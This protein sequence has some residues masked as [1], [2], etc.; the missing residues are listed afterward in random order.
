M[1]MRMLG[2][3][4]DGHTTSTDSS[5]HHTIIPIVGGSLCWFCPHGGSSGGIELPGL[6][7]P[8]VF[9]PPPGP[10]GFSISA[11]A[12]SITID[13]SGD[14]TY[15]SEPT[16][17]PSSTAISKSQSSSSGSSSSSS[18]CTKSI[19]ASFCTTS[20]IYEA[21][22]ASVT[23]TS[24]TTKCSTTTAC[25]A[26]DQTTTIKTTTTSTGSACSRVPVP[27][28][29]LLHMT[30]CVNCTDILSLLLR[31]NPAAATG[32]VNHIASDSANKNFQVS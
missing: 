19:T 23:S 27:S 10:P 8:G 15:S 25:S 24:T 20:L 31:D 9:P 7:F 5:G 2:E 13:S 16:S 4:T 12:P 3:T 18:S 21:N 28:G 26:T 1:L 14:P 22:T 30:R 17:S 11:N 6:P 32:Y 29:T